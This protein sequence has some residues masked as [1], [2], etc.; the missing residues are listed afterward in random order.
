ML[1]AQDV[2]LVGD[3]NTLSC[4]GHGIFLVHLNT[5]YSAFHEKPKLMK[6]FG[7]EV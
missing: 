6:H 5:A 4:Q 3:N 7:V 2:M 1:R